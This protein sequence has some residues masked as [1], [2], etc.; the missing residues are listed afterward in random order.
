M[1]LTKA[2]YESL[3][4]DYREQEAEYS[5]AAKYAAT[6]LPCVW[7]YP[8]D[9]HDPTRVFEL[10]DGFV[11]ISCSGYTLSDSGEDFTGSASDF[12]PT[13][14]ALM[15]NIDETATFDTSGCTDM[16]RTG[17]NKMTQTEPQNFLVPRDDKPSLQFDGQLLAEMASVPDIGSSDFSGNTRLWTELKL[18]RTAGGKLIC[19][20]HK[21]SRWAGHLVSSTAAVCDTKDEVIAFFGHGWLAGRIY[22]DAE[23]EDV[24]LVP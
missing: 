20:Q 6:G 8:G 5:D 24:E 2:Q 21:L 16:N 7:E 9:S 10:A 14:E 12:H 19:H 3:V 15:K 22:A 17:E 18:Y 11:A 4:W 23:I 13:N 1:K